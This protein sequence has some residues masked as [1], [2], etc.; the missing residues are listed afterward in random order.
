[1]CGVRNFFYRR[2]KFQQFSIKSFLLVQG[3]TINVPYISE[4]GRKDAQQLTQPEFANERRKGLYHE[5][6]TLLS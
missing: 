1:M 2:T 3:V 6:M 4:R 5:L